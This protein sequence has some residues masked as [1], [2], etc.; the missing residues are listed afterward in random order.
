M[1]NHAQTFH[2]LRCLMYVDG[3]LV[4][5]GDS[6]EMSLLVCSEM[7]LRICGRCAG[8]CYVRNLYTHIIPFKTSAF[9]FQVS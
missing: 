8:L 3:N 2:H 6:F 7:R 4:V 5:G 9:D 1:H